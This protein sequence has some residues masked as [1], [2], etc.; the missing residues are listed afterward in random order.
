LHIS[1]KIAYNRIVHCFFTTSTS[2]TQLLTTFWTHWYLRRIVASRLLESGYKTGFYTNLY[3]CHFIHS[4]I[5]SFIVSSKQQCSTTHTEISDN[6]T[7]ITCM[8]VI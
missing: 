5:H 2:I 3:T 7:R 4:F 8:C 6:I 1:F